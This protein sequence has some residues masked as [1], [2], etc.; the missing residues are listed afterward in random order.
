MPAA[1]CN[2]IATLGSLN[3][4]EDGC[5]KGKKVLRIA[6]ARRSWLDLENS[7]V[8]DNCINDIVMSGA[9][10]FFE[11]LGIDS[12]LITFNSTLGDDGTRTNTLTI[13]YASCNKIL[14]KLQCD[15]EQFC[16]WVIWIYTDN[17]KCYLLGVENLAGVLGSAYNVRP[18]GG[19]FSFGGTANISNTQVF[20]WRSNCLIHETDVAYEDLPLAPAA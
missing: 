4:S 16:D 13:D 20:N 9:D 14:M 8:T 17:C 7:T 3:I 12:D 11:I 5:A 19:T 10:Q 2:T 1:D 18:D 15:M 6:F